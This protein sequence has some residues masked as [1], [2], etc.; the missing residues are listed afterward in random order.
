MGAALAKERSDFL[1]LLDGLLT[2]GPLLGYTLFRAIC[3]ED[4]RILARLPPM[5]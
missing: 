1:G 4:E 5:G 3:A 2:Y